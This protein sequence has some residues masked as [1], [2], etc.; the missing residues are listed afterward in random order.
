MNSS[1]TSFLENSMANILVLSQIWK[2]VL[3]EGYPQLPSIASDLSTN[4]LHL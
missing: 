4:Y 1:L 2:N 3:V